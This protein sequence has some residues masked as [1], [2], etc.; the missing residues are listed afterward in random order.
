MPTDPR[1]LAEIR[2]AHERQLAAG[3]ALTSAKLDEQYARFQESFGPE[4]LASID[5]EE[6]LMR[7]HGRGNKRSLAYWLE[8]KNDDEFSGARFGSIAGGSALKFGIYCRKETGTWMTGS[9]MNQVE[10][11]V[12]EAV[13]LV[14]NQRD[15]LVAASQILKEQA[16]RGDRSIDYPAL[17]A[18]ILKACPDV[19]DSVWGHKY[20]SL[21]FPEILDSFHSPS[22]Q[23]F[24][25]VKCL[26]VP[27]TGGRYSA[28]GAFARLAH[29][30]DLRLQPL[31]VALNERHGVPHRYWRVGT[32]I[33][34]P[35]DQWPRMKAESYIAVGWD[36]VGDLSEIPRDSGGKGQVQALLERHYPTT[37]QQTGKDREQLWRML[38]TIEEDDIVFAADGQMVLGIGRVRGD[39]A[40]VSGADAPHRRRVEW[41]D[42]QEWK[43]PTGEGL[44]STCRPITKSENQ[45]AIEAHLLEGPT[46][47]LGHTHPPNATPRRLQGLSGRIQAI[48]E[49]K[50]QVILHGPP[51]T[52]KTYWAVRTARELAARSWFSISYDALNAEQRAQLEAGTGSPAALHVCTFHPSFGYEDFLEGFRPEKGPDGQLSFT[53]RDGLFKRMATWAMAAPD[54]D[55]YLIVDE[56]NRGDVPRIFGELL[57][58]LEKSKRGKSVQL[59]LSGSAFSIPPNLFLIGTMNTADRSI[60]L[61][62]AAL[63]RRFGFVE[64]MP[65]SQV[66]GNANVAGIP[67]GP[68]LDALNERV[69]RYVGRD[70]RNLQVGHSYLMHGDAPILDAGRFVHAVQ[71]EIVPLLQEYCYEDYET[72][73]KL[74]GPSLVDKASQAIR[75][76]LFT[77]TSRPALIQ[78]LLEPSPDLASS[79]R[80]VAAEAAAEQASQELDDPDDEVGE[81]APQDEASG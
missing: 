55:F 5:G 66:L 60:A 56:I 68:W 19:A 43:L 42:V 44:Q 81:A 76:H 54:R 74:L 28:A 64:L 21:L 45:I 30:L 4:V 58:I 26:Q 7:M 59:S 12:S 20:L 35:R 57:T 71:D 52:G 48:L 6:L 67:L 15:Q 70:A 46:V 69:L 31:T 9:A 38:A 51:G 77:P 72:L 23:S 33:Q 3:E 79:Q 47:P 73:E 14:R 80:A 27:T 78:A 50:A 18:R 40:F 49:R 29:E 13:G 17:E 11:T 2:A 1:V 63:R 22:Y 36:L 25:I 62:D 16:D 24:H 65:D 8:F 32:A 34:T 53:R 10:H 37:P 75:S 61:L 41:L 39:Y